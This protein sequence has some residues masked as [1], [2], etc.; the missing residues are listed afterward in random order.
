MNSRSRTECTLQK[1]HSAAALG[2]N[3]Q[4]HGPRVRY[5]YSLGYG[6]RNTP[7]SGKQNP[8]KKQL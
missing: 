7:A 5:V 4:Q 2:W 6:F 3:Q 8:T 1:L